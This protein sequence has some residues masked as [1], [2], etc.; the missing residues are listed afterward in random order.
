MTTKTKEKTKV[1]G[2][3]I[4][5]S[6]PTEEARRWSFL[7]VIV[8]GRMAGTSCD[9]S[10]QYARISYLLGQELVEALRV[11]RALDAVYPVFRRRFVKREIRR[12]EFRHVDIL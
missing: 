11:S 2:Q 8:A 4:D 6:A 9:L 5:R 3:S 12:V 1:A 7:G 10:Q